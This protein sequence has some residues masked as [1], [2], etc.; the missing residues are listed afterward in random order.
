VCVQYARIVAGESVF[1]VHWVTYAC[2]TTRN[3]R[4]GYA[5]LLDT[6]CDEPKGT[7]VDEARGGSQEQAVYQMTVL[8]AHGLGRDCAAMAFAGASR[9]RLWMEAPGDNNSGGNSRQRRCLHLL[10]GRSR[11]LRGC[12]RW[13]RRLLPALVKIPTVPTSWCNLPELVTMR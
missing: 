11:I 7:M 9:P 6:T 8:D 2:L 10:A 13:V 12:C 1:E 3:L 5:L 4:H